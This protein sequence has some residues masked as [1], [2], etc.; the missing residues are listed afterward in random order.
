MSDARLT[1]VGHR[2]AHARSDIIAAAAIAHFY[3]FAGQCMDWANTTR[4]LQERALYRQMALQWLAAAARLQTF[5]QFKNPGASERG[6]PKEASASTRLNLPASIS[7]PHP[8]GE[9]H[10]ATDK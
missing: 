2:K 3:N 4:S 9:L 7:R 8:N 1:D 6:P 5:A 10:D